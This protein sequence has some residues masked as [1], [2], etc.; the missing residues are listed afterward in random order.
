MRLYVRTS[1]FLIHTSYF[2]LHPSYFILQ[3]LLEMEE[4]LPTCGRAIQVIPEAILIDIKT[5]ITKQNPNK[6][7][8]YLKEKVR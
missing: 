5:K 4:K 1:A 2:I 6:N 8:F 3:L 7:I